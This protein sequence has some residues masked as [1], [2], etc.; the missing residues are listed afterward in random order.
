M[1]ASTKETDTIMAPLTSTAGGT[2]AL[3]RI[4]GPDAI[5]ICARFFQPH[6]LL[7]SEGGRFFYGRLI[8]PDKAIVDEVLVY[9]FKSPNSFTGEDVVEISCHNNI[10]ILEDIVQMLVEAGCRLAEPGEF[11]KRA[12]LN[13]KIDLVQAEAI[14]D[15]IAAKSRASTRNSLKM[16]EGRLSKELKAL[17]DKL[18]KMASMLELELDFSEEDLEII[19]D[20]ELLRILNGIISFTKKLQTSYK[21]SRMLHKG[22][23]V[24]I[25]GK[26]NVGKS[27]LMNAL[28]NKDRVIVSSIPGTTRDL[29]HEDILM[30]D[31]LVRLIDTAGI[32]FTEDEIEAEGVNRA[33]SLLHD[34]DMVLFLIDLSDE[35][36]SD[37]KEM[38]ES[39]LNH[40]G[41]RVILVGNKTDLKHNPHSKDF[42]DKSKA[43]KVSISAYDGG[44]LDSLKR[45]ITNTV[46]KSF[47]QSQED[48]LITNQRQFNVLGRVEK[49]L[50]QAKEALNS[51]M[52]SEFIAIHIRD[53]IDA[54]SELTGVISTDDILNSIFKDF[55]IGK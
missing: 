15:L 19:A 38:L 43:H 4:S 29:I 13:N 37:E 34:S 7:E 18:I 51:K 33:K 11:S 54:L 21:N 49:G 32:R 27:S 5:T 9:V 40:V 36:S 14:A 55:C 26:P 44:G 31:V 53:A 3:I 24:L 45:L 22:A 42:F 35:V 2:V 47:T 52:S 48:I 10:F 20:D 28:L 25:A 23:E 39:L 8:K 50:T 16:L 41:E 30:D 17:K 12:F 46:K 6:N 1:T